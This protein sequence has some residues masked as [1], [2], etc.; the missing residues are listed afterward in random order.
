VSFVTVA[1]YL[2]LLLAG[3]AEGLIG[4]FQYSRLAPV[5][6]MLFG[7][8]IFLTC[9]AAGWGMQSITGAFM[10]GI[11]WII[12]S[13]VMAQPMTNGSVIIANTTAGK[14]FLYGGTLGATAGAV[15]AFALWLRTAR[16]PLRPPP[17]TVVALTVVA[18]RCQPP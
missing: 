16:R 18:L 8:G 13:F 1:A 17:V 3:A 4:S 12:A 11:G 14:W 7:A 6:A 15:I 5:G 9:L 2:M 10:P